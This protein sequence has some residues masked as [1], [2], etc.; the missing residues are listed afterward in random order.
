MSSSD[1]QYDQPYPYRPRPGSEPYGYEPG[2]EPEPGGRQAPGGQDG[3]GGYGAPGEPRAPRGSEAPDGQVHQTWQGETWDTAYQPVVPAPGAPADPYAPGS[4]D[5]YASYGSSAPADPYGSYAPQGSHGSRSPQEVPGTQGSYGSGDSYGSE[6]SHDS[7]DSHDSHDSH[8]SY[9]PAGGPAPGQPHAGQP[10]QSHAGPAYAPYES[11]ESYAG[12]SYDIPG[13]YQD[14]PRGHEQGPG[15]GPGPLPPEA[16]GTGQDAPTAL[17]RPVSDGPGP[18]GAPGSL[19]GGPGDPATALLR[20]VGDGPGGPGRPAGTPVT[21]SAPPTAAEKARAEGR[22]IIVEPG[23]QP[24][25]LTAVLGALL[26]GGAALGPY[27]LLLPLVLLQAVTAAGWFRLNGMWP[28]R[29]GIALAF[30]GGLVADAALLVAGEEHAPAA[31]LGTLGVWVLLVLVLQLR[32]RAGA[33]ERLYGLMVTL[34]SSALAIVAAG[35]LASVLAAPGGTG[36][37]TGAAVLTGGLAVAAAILFRAL[38][39]PGALSVAV[40]LAAAAG[41]GF[42]LGGATGLGSGGALLGLGTGV[43][44]LV[45]HR[46]ASYDYPSRFVHLTAGVALPLAVAA[47]AVCLLGRALG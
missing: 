47:P 11:Y 4:Q 46:A 2:Y 28:A 3:H 23:L 21:A 20:P 5:P 40:A 14:A 15:Q 34:V 39:L 16:P 24:A 9:G 10:G 30:L 43:C 18:A 38:P 8:G 19:A 29:Q 35:Y 37:A 6:N 44:A 1:Q 26:A 17:L 41:A 36:T 25:A 7:F 42:A 13:A 27:G 33:D 12:Q 32:S 22:P 45:G 31:L